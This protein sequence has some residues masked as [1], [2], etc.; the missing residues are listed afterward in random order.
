MSGTGGGFKKFL[1]GE[2]DISDAE[3]WREKHL[4]SVRHTY[5]RRPFFAEGMAFLEAELIGRLAEAAV[6]YGDSGSP[7]LISA[8]GALAVSD[9]GG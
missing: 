4:A 5:A 8:L 2:I 1:R 7:E 9:I 3:P 6:D